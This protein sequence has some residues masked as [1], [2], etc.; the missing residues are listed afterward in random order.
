MLFRASR[1]DR[2][3]LGAWWGEVKILARAEVSWFSF[4]WPL[5]IFYKKIGR[6]R[7]GCIA[8][9]GYNSS[10]PSEACFFFLAHRGVLGHITVWHRDAI[11]AAAAVCMCACVCGS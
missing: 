11:V 3:K 1:A 9:T 2:V 10:P 8:A 4:S 6:V 7:R 5:M